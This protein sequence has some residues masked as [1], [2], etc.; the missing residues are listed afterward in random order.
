LDFG[1]RRGEKLNHY[2]VRRKR[3]RLPINLT[4]SGN[5]NMAK[6]VNDS[7]SEGTRGILKETTNKAISQ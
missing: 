1:A 5:E 6:T 2:A 4:A 7:D 3:P